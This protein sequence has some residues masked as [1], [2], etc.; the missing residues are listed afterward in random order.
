MR[1]I[2]W[3]P[4]QAAG[5]TR[6]KKAAGDPCENMGTRLSWEGLREPP[7]VSSL[8]PLAR[9]VA[10]PCSFSGHFLGAHC[11]P[12]PVLSAGKRGKPDR[13]GLCPLETDISKSTTSTNGAKCSQGSEQMGQRGLN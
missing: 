5:G 11:V 4:E 3:G 10:V 7:A 2:G 9:W 1:A 12:G 6:S 8:V 13:Y